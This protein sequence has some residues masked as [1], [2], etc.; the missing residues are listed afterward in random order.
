M[1]FL[2]FHQNDFPNLIYFLPLIYTLQ[3]TCSYVRT[4]GSMQKERGSRVIL[5]FSLSFLLRHGVTGYVSLLGKASNDLQFH[6]CVWSIC[7]CINDICVYVEESFSPSYM[8][9]SLNGPSMISFI[10]RYF[11]ILFSIY[12][13]H[14]M[15]KDSTFTSF[16]TLRYPKCSL[17]HPHCT[18]DGNL[19]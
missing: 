17:V 7:V 14:C 4:P 12:F 9:L 19:H 11:S 13:N 18:P 15:E 3:S 16:E 1:V 2:M 8:C 6:V 10:P 5:F